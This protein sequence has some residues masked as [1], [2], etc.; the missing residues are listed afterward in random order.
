VTRVALVSGGLGGIGTAVCRRLAAAGHRV[1]AADL[2]AEAA[3]LARFQA[4][5]AGLDVVVETGDASDYDQ[6]TALVGRVAAAHGPVDVLVNAAGITR[7]SSFKK[8]TPEQWHEVMR[9][10]LD[11]AFNL[12]KHVVDGMADRGFGRIVSISSIVGQTGAF[13]QT[14]YAAS[15][16]GLHGFTMAL[17]REVARKGVTVNSVSP[18]YIETAMTAAIP[19]DVRAQMVS[20]IPVGRIGQPDDVAQSVAFLCSDAAAYLTGVN[21]PVNGGLFLSF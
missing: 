5:V 17:A 12:S 6:C 10:N 4:D 7:D 14:N 13:G 11:S 19:T 21:L 2:P 8:M 9:A 20:A 18:G 3:R 16:A 1:V 15:K